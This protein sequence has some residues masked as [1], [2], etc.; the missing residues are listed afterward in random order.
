MSIIIPTLTVSLTGEELL[1]IIT[2]KLV[3]EKNFILINYDTAKVSKFLEII[4][5]KDDN[6]VLML[7][8]T[9]RESDESA[10]VTSTNKF[11]IIYEKKALLKLLVEH[12]ANEELK[13]SIVNLDFS[14]ENLQ[15]KDSNLLTQENKTNVVISFK[16]TLTE[17]WH[18]VD[19]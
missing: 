12:T 15:L 17:N 13:K 4:K 7:S 18:E 19:K 10:G 9:T 8:L 3:G 1:E 2:K 5:Q 11:N 16:F 14:I 6:F